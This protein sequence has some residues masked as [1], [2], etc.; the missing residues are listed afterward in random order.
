MKK[1]I[2]TALIT[3]MAIAGVSSAIAAPNN[4]PQ[5]A[6]FKKAD[7]KPLNITADEARTIVSAMMIRHGKSDRQIIQKVDTISLDNHQ[8]GNLNFYVV[9][10]G[11]KGQTSYSNFFIVN[12]QNGRV[13][14]Y[15]PK[16]QHKRR[17][18]PRA[19]RMIQPQAPMPTQAINPDMAT[20]PN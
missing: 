10:V 6:M 8:K 17:P 19:F 20:A 3:T 5:T 4:P 18:M 11:N 13:Q 15:P 9:Y 7:R 16:C 2:T 1:L 14:A 12:A